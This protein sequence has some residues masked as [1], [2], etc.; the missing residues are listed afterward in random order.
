[1]SL[2]PAGTARAID[3]K[4]KVWTIVLGVDGRLEERLDP[5]FLA[6]FGAHDRIDAI[7]D[8]LISASAEQDIDETRIW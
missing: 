8:A 1:L 7:I 3:N 4:A 6:S 2:G 5:V